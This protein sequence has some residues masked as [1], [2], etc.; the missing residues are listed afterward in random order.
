MEEGLGGL[1]A[2]DAYTAGHGFEDGGPGVEGRE[3]H[4][5]NLIPSQCAT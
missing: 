4:H 5:N 2:V 1:A 3:G